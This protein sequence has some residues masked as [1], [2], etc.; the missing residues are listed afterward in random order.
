MRSY[1][2]PEIY[3]NLRDAAW[4]NVYWIPHRARRAV[5]LTVWQPIYFALCIT[6][7]LLIALLMGAL[8]LLDHFQERLAGHIFPRHRRPTR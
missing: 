7:F 2:Y 6:L 5:Y 4:H 3:R 1:N 8:C